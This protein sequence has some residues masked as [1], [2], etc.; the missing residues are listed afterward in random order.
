MTK[1]THNNRYRVFQIFRC[2]ALSETLM[3]IKCEKFLHRHNTGTYL[4]KQ[5]SWYL[6]PLIK[7]TTIKVIIKGA[8]V[9]YSTCK[10][11]TCNLQQRCTGSW[12]LWEWCPPL[13]RPTYQLKS[14]CWSIY[15]S[16]LVWVLGKHQASIGKVSVDYRLNNSQV[17]FQYCLSIRRV[18]VKC[19]LSIHPVLVEYRSSTSHVSV[20]C[21][22]SVGG[23][24]VEYQLSI[25]RVSVECL[26]SV[27][28]V[29]V[30]CWLRAGWVLL[31]C[32]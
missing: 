32:R 19:H 27:G 14:T 18:S 1:M 16:S 11:V 7:K 3:I 22:K 25:G 2:F 4:G 20:A 10:L 6:H 5:F 9:L 26:S 24:S 12:V 23:V 29:S 8:T 21:W 31:E 17:L 13:Y 28:W 15:W 30:K